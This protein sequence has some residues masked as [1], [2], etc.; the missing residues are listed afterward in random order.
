MD[1]LDSRLRHYFIAI[2]NIRKLI[3]LSENDCQ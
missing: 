3:G 1:E 2:N